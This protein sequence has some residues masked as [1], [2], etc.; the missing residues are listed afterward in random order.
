M[1]L[2]LIIC[3]AWKTACRLGWAIFALA[4]AGAGCRPAAPPAPA[5]TAT[6]APTRAETAPAGL[7]RPGPLRIMPLGDSLTGGGNT[8]A[9]HTYRGYLEALLREAGYAFDF[10]GTQSG[11]AY[12]GSDPDHEGHG[13]FT[14]G[15]DDIRSRGQ[16]VS[17]YAYLEDYL[18]AGPDVILLLIGIN[19]LYAGEISPGAPQLAAGRLVGLVERIQALRPGVTIFVASLAPASRYDVSTRVEFKAVN[20]AAQALGEA[21]PDDA[22]YFVDLYGRLAPGW[23]PA[24][25]LIDGVHFSE[26]GARKVAQV[27]FEALVEAGVLVGDRD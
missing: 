6:L 16:P 9:S 3:S 8:G 17:L 14:I 25:D 10:V 4:L 11:L 21:D 15:P 12:G 2:R 24:A 23:D 27:W 5:A 22:V 13:S 18:R 7:R 1:D 20:A 19:D 26:R